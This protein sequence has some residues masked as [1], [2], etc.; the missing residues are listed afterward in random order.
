VKTSHLDIQ[1]VLAKQGVIALREHPDLVGPIRW[2]ARRGDLHV[3]A[4]RCI[5]AAVGR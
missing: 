2:L 5:C 4:A 3:S 1:E